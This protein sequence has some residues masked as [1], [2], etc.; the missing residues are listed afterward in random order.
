MKKRKVASLCLAVFLMY[1]GA[2][3][4]EEEK[5]EAKKENVS[6]EQKGTNLRIG[7]GSKNKE[8][9]TATYQVA[10]GY[11]AETAAGNALAAGS[12]AKAKGV[13]SIAVGAH[14]EA[15]KDSATAIG[16]NAKAEGN[17]S[18]AIGSNAE[19]SG[20]AAMALGVQSNAK[21]QGAIAVG[22]L[23]EVTKKSGIGIGTNTKVNHTN[24]V[25]V[26]SYVT[27][28]VDNSVYLGNQSKAASTAHSKRMEEYSKE[29][30][31]GR[32][33]SFA[34]GK[35][36]GIVTVG[37]EGREKRIQNVAAGWIDENSTDAVNGSQLYA[38]KTEVEKNKEEL[39]RQGKTLENIKSEARY[40]GALSSALAALNPMEYDPMKPN[41]VLA[42]FG[43][44]K[45]SQAVAVGISHH[46]NEN[47]RAQAGV[48]IGEGKRTESMVNLG[49]SWK[50]GKD[51]RDESYDK[52][53]EGPI[54]SIYIMQD[55][56]KQVMEEN[57]K[58]KLELEEVKKQLQML[59]K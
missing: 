8:E 1:G 30:I 12:L 7:K 35:A 16:P 6:M 18:T 38:V 33:H 43:N 47:V 54:S 34:G 58:L 25:V 44:Y 40:T 14:S 20:S 9:S 29:I 36:S 56:M 11:Q 26:G 41:Q 52:Y 31:N 32:E 15:E 17:S 13:N 2:A 46:F 45:N 37:Q 5:E 55:E 28:E 59:I 48:A 4:A 19:A 10:I 50:I 24:S 53:K 22:H 39:D 3:F 23:S 51:D 21:G 49:F 42:G 57:R 27:T